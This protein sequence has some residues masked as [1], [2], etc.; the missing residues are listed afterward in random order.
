MEQQ[1]V[2]IA[3]AGIQASLNARCS[4]VAAANPVYG[5]YDASI[6]PQRNV[7]LPDSLLSRFDV[8]FIVLDTLDDKRDAQIAEH[9]LRLHRY[10]RPGF[11]GRP[12]PLDASAA[13]DD[14]DEEVEREDGTS[15]VLVKF[16]PLLHSGA[17][18]EARA[19]AKARGRS[20]G[21]S[22][23]VELLDIDFLK[24][25]ISYAKARVRPTL[26]DDARE[27]IGAAYNQLRQRSEARAMPVTARTLETLIRLSTGHAKA[28]LSPI[29]EAADVTEAVGILNYSFFSIEGEEGGGIG[30][31]SASS[32]SARDGG[33]DDDDD[34]EEDEDGSGGRSK[35]GRSKQTASRDVASRTAASGGNDSADDEGTFDASVPSAGGKR[36]KT[37]TGRRRGGERTTA[38]SA[39]A[40]AAIEDD[41]EE[42]EEEEDMVVRTRQPSSSSSSSSS[43]ASSKRRAMSDEDL[44]SLTRAVNVVMRRSEGQA[45]LA[46]VVR[47]LRISDSSDKEFVSDAKAVNGITEARLQELTETVLENK[48]ML[49]DEGNLLSV[50]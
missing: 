5:Q 14:D 15:R 10:Q 3:K 18:E 11:E 27:G 28:R 9:V 8:L 43:S 30:K 16:S 25:F 22:G 7:N 31:A 39:A 40:S 12:V 21:R 29:V 13:E 44:A 23:T 38:P 50:V 20:F 6:S 47:V 46:D 42:E 26:T 24:K 48:L 2:T 1:T 32:A 33:S 45:R 41:D 17:I 37:V 36:S 4:V 49:D 35:R 34:E 19:D